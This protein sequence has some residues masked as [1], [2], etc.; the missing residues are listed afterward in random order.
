MDGE[1]NGRGKPFQMD[2]V[3]GALVV[4]GPCECR[5]GMDSM[6]QLTLW[7]RRGLREGARRRKCHV[8]KEAGPRDLL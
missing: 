7:R 6:G 2:V 3:D 4:T 1:D 5:L 8:Q